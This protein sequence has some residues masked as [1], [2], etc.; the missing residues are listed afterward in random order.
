MRQATKSIMFIA[1]CSKPPRN[2]LG[3]EMHTREKAVSDALQALINH[4]FNTDEE[5]AIANSQSMLQARTA[6]AMPIEGEE[7]QTIPTTDAQMIA[8]NEALDYMGFALLR[9][10]FEPTKDEVQGELLARSLFVFIQASTPLDRQVLLD[11]L[12]NQQTH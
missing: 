4:I 8:A 7:P 3:I 2:Q 1:P 12:E 5:G 10:G 6:L 11:E 9:N